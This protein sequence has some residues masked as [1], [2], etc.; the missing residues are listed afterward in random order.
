[1]ST[2]N[3]RK[4]FFRFKLSRFNSMHCFRSR[5]LIDRVVGIRRKV[6]PNFAYHLTVLSTRTSTTIYFQ[7]PIKMLVL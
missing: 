5:G 1:M 3:L 4:S 2:A 7:L 6:M